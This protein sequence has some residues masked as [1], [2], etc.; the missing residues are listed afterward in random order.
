MRKFLIT[1]FLSVYV[2]SFAHAELKGISR[3]N[4]LIED[5]SNKAVSCGVTK[6]KIETSVKYILSNSKIGITD[7]FKIGTPTLYIQ[8]TVSENSGLCYSN[9]KLEV[10]EY[11]KHPISGNYGD[12]VYFSSSG[13]H[14]NSKS[15]F[16]SFFF[17]ELEDRVKRFV[18]A[19]NKEN[20]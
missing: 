11:I 1:I 13:I 17:D 2:S 20:R 16:A 12:F 5:L 7:K 4:I 19:H 14:S 10:Y 3:V 9:T 6:K 18:V 15:G 8:A